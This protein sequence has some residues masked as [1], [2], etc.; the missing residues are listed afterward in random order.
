MREEGRRERHAARAGSAFVVPLLFAVALALLA[1]VAAPVAVRADDGDGRPSPAPPA[2]SSDDE[3]NDGAGDEA[4]AEAGASAAD[5]DDDEDGR[6]KRADVPERPR[7]GV[8]GIGRPGR[9]RRPGAGSTRL[10]P[11]PDPG[12]FRARDGAIFAK[13]G[14]GEHPVGDDAGFAAERPRRTEAVG[15]FLIDRREVSRA[16]YASFLAALRADREPHR[17]CHPG[18]PKGK[19]HVPDGW[20]E[21]DGEGDAAPLP[22]TNVDWFDAFAFAAWA[23]GRLPTDLEWEA[24]ARGAAGRRHPWG[25]EPPDGSRAIFGRHRAGVAPVGSR[26]SG[27]TPE[28]VLDLAGNVWE[29]AA[30]AS[31][32]GAAAATATATGEGAGGEGGDGAAAPAVPARVAVRG[33]SWLS[34]ADDLRAARRE[35]RGPLDRHRTIGFRVARDVPEGDAPA[36]AP[37]GPPPDERAPGADGSDPKDLDAGVGPGGR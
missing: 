27:A 30:P 20:A 9:P 8:P 4:E 15:A 16:R 5:D 1:A 13:V 22:V 36:D 32:A 2:T 6:K 14:G 28:G 35:L 33:G 29:W 11:G 25:E 18:E 10:Q 12:T 21:G 3:K 37:D 19:S 7:R 17:R 23:G 26:I 31:S 24:A 34:P